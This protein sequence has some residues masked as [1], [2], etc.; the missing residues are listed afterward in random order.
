MSGNEPIGPEPL[1]QDQPVDDATI[2]SRV[3]KALP[4]FSR[5][6]ISHRPCGLTDSGKP[7]GQRDAY[8]LRLSGFRPI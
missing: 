2:L 8:S 1:L 4:R 7:T 6:A 3:I 5:A